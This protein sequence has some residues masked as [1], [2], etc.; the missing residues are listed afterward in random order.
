MDDQ[1]HVTERKQSC[2]R[3]LHSFTLRTL[4]VLVA[5][6]AVGLAWLG[7]QVK[8]IHDRWEA[9]RRYAGMHIAEVC[10]PWSIRIFGEHG[11]GVIGMP[12]WQTDAERKELQGLFPEARI[13]KGEFNWATEARSETIIDPPLHSCD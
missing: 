1:P 7:V 4:F 12:P 9:R 8:W 5:V 2:F 10:A 3:P 6:M 11:I 13:E